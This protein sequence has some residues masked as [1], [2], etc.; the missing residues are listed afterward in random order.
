MQNI[1]IENGID[2]KLQ[3]CIPIHADWANDKKERKDESSYWEHGL[4]YLFSWLFLL[5]RIHDYTVQYIT[6]FPR[7]FM[8]DTLVVVNTTYRFL[9]GLMGTKI[10]QMVNWKNT[11]HEQS[12]ECGNSG[13]RQMGSLV[14]SPR[15]GS[16]RSFEGCSQGSCTIFPSTSVRV[17]RQ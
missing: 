10:W 8:R 1:E 13:F 3:Y 14:W 15:I 7:N 9:V 2:D 4:K 5:K 16:F 17:E 11:P 12:S 6:S